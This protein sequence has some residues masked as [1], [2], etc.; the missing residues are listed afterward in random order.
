[1]RKNRF[2]QMN[3][4]AAGSVLRCAFA[5]AAAA[6]FLLIAAA[7]LS[8][9]S[10]QAKAADGK[11][12]EPTVT[13]TQAVYGPEYFPIDQDHESKRTDA[14]GNEIL[15]DGAACA[16]GILTF[17]PGGNRSPEV[18]KGE[19]EKIIG[20]PDY[21]AETGEGALSLGTNGQIVLDFDAIIRDS[22]G[23]F[24]YVFT[25]GATSDQMSIAL[26]QDGNKWY[27]MEFK[28][29]EFTG[30][31]NYVNIPSTVKPRYVRIRD[32][33]KAKDGVAIDSV[34]IFAPESLKP[35]EKAGTEA[36]SWYEKFGLQKKAAYVICVTVASFFGVLIILLALRRYN[37]HRKRQE[38]KKLQLVYSR[39]RR[40]ALR[41]SRLRG[42]YA[43][44]PDSFPSQNEPEGGIPAEDQPYDEASEDEPVK[45]KNK[46][47]SSKKGKAKDKSTKRAKDNRKKR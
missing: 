19:M 41:G 24:L 34:V 2:G 18:T 46:A 23:V 17:R 40:D 5:I 37:I 44:G 13:P 36:K 3:G 30:V 25:T 7:S 27:E 39:G 33:G 32:N 35:D 29:R 9:L 1:M 42:D 14:F 11:S 47:K 38:K 10:G 12:A 8:V 20:W 26:S 15:L 16:K 31:D 4:K 43:A 22:S 6:V 21:D 45:E 28:N